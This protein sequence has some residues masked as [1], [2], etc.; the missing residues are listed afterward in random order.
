M[1]K[2][3]T[4]STFRTVEKCR[5]C[6]KDFSNVWLSSN[7]CCRLENTI[8]PKILLERPPD[9]TRKA[10][11]FVAHNSLSPWYTLQEGRCG[12][13]FSWHRTNKRQKHGIKPAVVSPW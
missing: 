4:S 6:K 8:L 10:R 9:N 13:G 5:N 7:L 2:M 1:S 12:Y 11:H 3:P